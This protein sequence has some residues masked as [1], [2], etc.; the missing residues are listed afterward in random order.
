MQQ[1]P[2]YFASIGPLFDP[3]IKNKSLTTYILTKT[4]NNQL[5]EQRKREN[6]MQQNTNN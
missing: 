3:I 4:Q 6:T 1:L 5:T 2:Q